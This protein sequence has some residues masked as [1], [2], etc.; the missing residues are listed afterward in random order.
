MERLT[1][2]ELGKTTGAVMCTY[3][4]EQCNDSCMYGMC[5]WNKK[6]LLKLKEYEDAGLEP[7]EITSL[8][9]ALDLSREEVQGLSRKLAEYQRLEQEGLL[10]DVTKQMDLDGTKRIIL[11]LLENQIGVPIPK[12]QLSEWVDDFLR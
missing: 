3:T 11:T 5:K 10:F 4:A 7:S 1:R 12:E 6:A 8:K 2:Q 9:E